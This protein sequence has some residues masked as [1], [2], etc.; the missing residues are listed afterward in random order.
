MCTH[1]TVKHI[2]IVNWAASRGLST[3]IC[4]IDAARLMTDPCVYV[5]RVSCHVSETSGNRSCH[6]GA[7]VLGA[8]DATRRRQP[9]RAVRSTPTYVFAPRGCTSRLHLA[10]RLEPITMVAFAAKSQRNDGLI[11]DHWLL[12]TIAARVLGLLFHCPH[13]HIRPRTD[14]HISL[15]SLLPRH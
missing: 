8:P 2:Q 5:A 3:Q 10:A 4:S 11:R 1:A 15:L 9:E 6:R 12:I 14:M 7:W 13:S